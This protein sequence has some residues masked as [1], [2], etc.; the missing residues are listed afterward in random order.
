MTDTLSTDDEITRIPVAIWDTNRVGLMKFRVN[1][2]TA[3][4]LD[5]FQ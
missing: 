2:D 5:D 4:G 3:G 1:I